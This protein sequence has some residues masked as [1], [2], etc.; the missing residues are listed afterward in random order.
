MRFLNIIWRG[1][2]EACRGSDCRRKTG[3]PRRSFTHFLVDHQTATRGLRSASFANTL[4]GEVVARLRIALVLLLVNDCLRSVGSLPDRAIDGWMSGPI[5][6]SGWAAGH[7]EDDQR[8]TGGDPAAQTRRDSSASGLLREA[9]SSVLPRRQCFVVKMST[10][11]R[12]VR[13]WRRVCSR[14]EIMSLCPK[15][16]AVLGNVCRWS[17]WRGRS[18]RRSRR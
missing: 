7:I 11:S 3:V 16:G 10:A 13:R 8:Q 5:A 17:R 9:A 14:L 12:I 18:G 1:R 15:P 4:G 2:S 6:G